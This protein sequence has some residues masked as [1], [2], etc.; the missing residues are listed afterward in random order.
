EVAS[1]NI[2]RQA[3]V[4]VASALLVDYVMTVAVS[5]SSGGDN[6]ISAIPSLPAPRVQLAL[7][8]VVLLAAM[9]LR[10]VREA[11]TAF[12]LPTYAFAF[13]VGIMI[14]TGIFRAVVGN[15]PVAESAN[16]HIIPQPGYANM[17]TLALI[18]FALRAFSSGCTA[19]T[20]VEAIANGVPAFRKPKAINARITL[21]MM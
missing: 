19:L 21:L 20:G 17:G 8:F 9:N 12:A 4:I 2:G 3:G 14:V 13:G 18:F 7:A 5:V 1:K 16:Y 6:I 11:G 10:G 15:P